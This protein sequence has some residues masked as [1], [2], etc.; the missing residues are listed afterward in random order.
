MCVIIRDEIVENDE[1]RKKRISSWTR[2]AGDDLKL[3]FYSTS[4]FL[5]VLYR[6]EMD[7]SLRKHRIAL[8]ESLYRFFLYVDYV[9][10]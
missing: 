1:T 9:I 2:V 10:R 4:N 3:C 6:R 7:D 5:I 8:I